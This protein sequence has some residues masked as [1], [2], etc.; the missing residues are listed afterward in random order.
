[1]AVIRTHARNRGLRPPRLGDGLIWL[2]LVMGAAL[3]IFPV[4]WLFASAVD[5]HVSINELWPRTW[6]FNSFSDAWA[7]QPFGRWFFNSTLIAVVSVAITVS[8][9]LLAGYTFAKYRFP[10]RT[11]IF[12][13]ILITLMVPI[14]VIL[15]PEFLLV[16]RMHLL[17]SIWSVILPRVAEPFG[18]FMA[19]QFFLSIPDEI[20]EAARIDGAGDLAVF[21]RVV[22]PLSGPVIA[23]LTIFT[24][25]YRWNDF[26]WPLVVLQDINSFTVTLGLNSMNGVYHVPETS[27]MAMSLV[28]ILPMMIVFIIFQRYFVAG[29]A[30]TGTR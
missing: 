5:P 10:G 1:M 16:V 21:L 13:A 17:G 18:I 4:Y 28:S 8:I 23:V 7:S 12:F 20:L 15:V 11:V 2:V 24:F 25:M 3:V 6:H 9:N 30:T 29:I 26:S 27:I 14:Q 22:L 19:R